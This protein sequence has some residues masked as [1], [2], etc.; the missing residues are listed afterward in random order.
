MNKTAPYDIEVFDM[1]ENGTNLYSPTVLSSSDKV[2]SYISN[3]VALTVHSSETASCI[4][5]ML[6][7]LSAAFPRCT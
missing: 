3:L 1:P 2:P 6:L 7:V 4:F 5:A